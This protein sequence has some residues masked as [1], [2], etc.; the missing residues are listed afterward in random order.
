[1]LDGVMIFVVVMEHNWYTPEELGDPI[2]ATKEVVVI[3]NV[4]H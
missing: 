3:H 1:M 2:I 4:Y